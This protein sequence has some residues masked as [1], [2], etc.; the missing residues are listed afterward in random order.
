MAATLDRIKIKIYESGRQKVK[1]VSV[2]N[3]DKIP[4]K[5]SFSVRRLFKWQVRSPRVEEMPPARVGDCDLYAGPSFQYISPDLL[6]LTR[7]LFC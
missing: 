7:I 3:V 2:F 4:F 1:L 6:I 5:S